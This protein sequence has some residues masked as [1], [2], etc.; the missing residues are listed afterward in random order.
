MTDIIEEAEYQLTIIV[1]D[2][3]DEGLSVYDYV[4][5]TTLKKVQKLLANYQ[6][7]WLPEED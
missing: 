1:G 4:P 6:V 3:D 7:A 2:D 5:G